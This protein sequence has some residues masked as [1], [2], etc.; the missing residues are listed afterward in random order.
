MLSTA[1]DLLRSV[2]NVEDFQM[3]RKVTERQARRNPD[4]VPNEKTR[5]SLSFSILVFVKSPWETSSQGLSRL[6]KS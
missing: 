6:V 1:S 4:R 5:P 2:H 3:P